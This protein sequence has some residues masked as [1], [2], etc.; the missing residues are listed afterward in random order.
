MLPLDQLKVQEINP[1]R[2]RIEH[3][4]EQ[5]KRYSDLEKANRKKK[6]EKEKA[7]VNGAT[8]IESPIKAQAVHLTRLI[9]LETAE[10]ANL[11]RADVN[12]TWLR[13]GTSESQRLVTESKA[14]QSQAVTRYADG[15]RGQLRVSGM[16]YSS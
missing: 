13:A 9:S 12:A 7:A 2:S 3:I 5:R 16:N 15:G 10:G 14:P 4:I 8:K 11:D 6:D 1:K